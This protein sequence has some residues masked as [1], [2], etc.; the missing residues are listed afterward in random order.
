MINC[1]KN[2]I[3]FYKRDALLASFDEE[4]WQKVVS[5]TEPG[6]IVKVIVLFENKFIVKKTT[7]YLVYDEKDI[8]S[9]VREQEDLKRGKK[10]H[11]VRVEPSSTEDVIDDAQTI[12]T[13]FPKL[14]TSE[15]SSKVHEENISSSAKDTTATMIETVVEE[16]LSKNVNAPV[17][18]KNTADVQVSEGDK[19]KDN[20]EPGDIDK[21]ILR[22]NKECSGESREQEHEDS[23]PV[24][25]QDKVSSQATSPSKKGGETDEEGP[26]VSSMKSPKTFN[27][28]SNMRDGLSTPSSL[29]HEPF[30]V[31]FDA[32]DF[33]NKLKQNPLAALD[34][35]ISSFSTSKNSTVQISQGS[36]SSNSS[37]TT[38][39][40]LIR[41]L[42]TIAFEKDLSERSAVGSTLRNVVD[43]FKPKVLAHEKLF[44]PLQLEYIKGLIDNLEALL[45]A[46]NDLESATAQKHHVD[47]DIELRLQEVTTTRS[48]IEVQQKKIGKCTSEET[49]ID[50]EII[51]LQNKI[52]DL[53]TKKQALGQTKEIAAKHLNLVIGKAVGLASTLK[54]LKAKAKTATSQINSAEQKLSTLKSVYLKFKEQS[55][56]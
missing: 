26:E 12:S 49:E 4:D 39:D 6:D 50:N 14:I 41:E 55:W 22:E 46:N 42:R 29:V 53:E 13:M 34:D 52:K 36:E 17:V 27:R 3:Q 38:T 31:E 28:N 10:I 11:D 37:E 54:G 33:Q 23:S 25:G 15:P 56:F 21:A 47:K 7:V 32:E 43:S 44:S 2:T 19:E 16:V 9:N 35:F 48:E 45:N 30:D 1:T 20:T 8:G 18:D 24:K 40:S 5:N 51:A